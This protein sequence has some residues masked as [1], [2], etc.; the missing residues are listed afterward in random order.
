MLDRLDWG[1]SMVMTIK[2]AWLEIALLELYLMRN[3]GTYWVLWVQR[4][5][6]C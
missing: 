4:I 1:H 2:I 5:Y 6:K 3:N